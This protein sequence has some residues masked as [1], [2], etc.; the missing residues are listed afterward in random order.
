MITT[1]TII[2]TR[3]RKTEMALFDT[4]IIVDWSAS[5]VPKR[6]KDSI[7]ICCRAPDGERFE[8]PSTRH[9]ARLLL[10]D[11]LAEAMANGERVLAGFDFPFGYPAGFAAR[12]S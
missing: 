12:L 2:R 7:W 1:I 5:N 11:M 4:Y 9:K 8:N 10:A 3:I 6:G